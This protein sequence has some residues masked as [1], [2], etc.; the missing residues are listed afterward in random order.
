MKKLFNA[1]LVMLLCSYASAYMNVSYDFT[2][3]SWTPYDTGALIAIGFVPNASVDQTSNYNDYLNAD[4]Y[5]AVYKDAYYSDNFRLHLWLNAPVSDPPYPGATLAFDQA[6]TAGTV[7]GKWG[8]LGSANQDSFIEIMAGSTR[9]GYAYPASYNINLNSDGYYSNLLD[10]DG[11]P[12]DGGG[13]NGK[14]DYYI[15]YNQPQQTSL[16]W[17][18]NPDGT[19]GKLTMTVDYFRVSDGTTRTYSLTQDFTGIGVPDSIRIRTGWTSYTNR[20]LIMES[21]SIQTSAIPEPFTMTLLVLGGLF[22]RR[23]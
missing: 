11:D 6:A 9:V 1:V 16:S 4:N 7:S 12:L 21:L 10:A 18:V 15:A 13:G 2:D 23:K 22:I 20:A 5:F 19:G 14:T 17:T 3:G 8:V